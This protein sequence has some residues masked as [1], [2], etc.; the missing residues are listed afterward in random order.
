MTRIGLITIGQAP[1]DDI[2]SEI[3]QFLPPD[4]EILQAGA[5]DGLTLREIFLHL[6][7]SEERTL[8]TRLVN[9][10]E[11]IVD[12]EFIYE[13]IKNIIHSLEKK[14]ELLGLLCSGSFPRLSSR[15][16][17]ILPYLLLEG[18]LVALSLPG[19]IGIVVPSPK[20]IVPVAQ[21][22][23]NL[24]IPAIGAAVSP[25]T[26]GHRVVE[27]A[28]SLVD[29]GAAAIVLHCFGYPLWTRNQVQLATGR[30]V[31]LVRSLFAR[32]LAELVQDDRKARSL[33]DHISSIK[34][35]SG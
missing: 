21:K 31:I 6:P 13:R 1:R 11:V 16:P 10:K 2:V 18:F 29:Q 25:Y 32:A 7:K 27:T 35:M 24:G 34:P 14:V 3:R 15:V 30:P 12:K 4:V 33:E 19:P 20:Q 23:R 26:E 17:L 22:L 9:G 8:V 28:R 5:L